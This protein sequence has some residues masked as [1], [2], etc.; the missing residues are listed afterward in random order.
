MRENHHFGKDGQ[1]IAYEAPF[2]KQ[3]LSTLPTTYGRMVWPSAPGRQV[4]G[5]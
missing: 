3:E 5:R 2:P 4:S 1:P